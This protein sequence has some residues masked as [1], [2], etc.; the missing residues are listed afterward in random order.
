MR[1]QSPVVLT[2]VRRQVGWVCTVIAHV[3]QLYSAGG[4]A[5]PRRLVAGSLIPVIAYVNERQLLET[6]VWS[7]EFLL[8]PRHLGLL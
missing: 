5:G 6:H 1:D 4:E 7:V 3:A 8:G 2:T